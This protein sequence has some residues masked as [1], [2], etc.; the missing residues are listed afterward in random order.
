[1][2]ARN[3]V[4][5]LTCVGGIAVGQVLFK[6]SARRVAGADGAGDLWRL[7]VSPPFLAALAVYGLASLLWV[8]VLREVPLSRAYPFF[9]LSFVLVPLMAWAFMGEPVTARYWAGVAV[10]VA[11]LVVIGG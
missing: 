3:L 4:L 2:G 9:A 10:L 8:W 11:G 6:L 1:M 5:L 7:V